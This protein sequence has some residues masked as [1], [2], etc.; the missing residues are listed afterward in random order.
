MKKVKRIT[1]P[2]IK[3][4]LEESLKEIRK[5]QKKALRE[6]FNANVKQG[7]GLDK[8]FSEILN[9]IKVKNQKYFSL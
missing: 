1:D 2:E 5:I 7:L 4:Q 3:K 9:T 6:M 8:E